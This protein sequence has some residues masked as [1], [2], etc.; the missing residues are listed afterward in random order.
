[1]RGRRRRRYEYECECKAGFYRNNEWN[2][3]TGSYTL[4]CVACPLGASSR[5][6][7]YCIDDCICGAG[8]YTATPGYQP[9][10]SVWIEKGCEACPPKSTSP[11]DSQSI[12]E[13]V[14]QAGFR[15]GTEGEAK[16]HS[17]AEWVV[18][19]WP[20]FD[21]NWITDV[22]DILFQFSPRPY[23]GQIV[24]NSNFASQEMPR[25]YGGTWEYEKRIPYFSGYSLA[26]W[27][28][29]VDEVGLDPR[30]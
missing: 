23:E 11:P 18:K 15:L 9:G 8:Y 16:D 6:G 27:T 14:C 21:V 29:T 7:S 12:S 30:L 20:E 17:V 13:R 24:M 5:Q 4:R 26:T 28:I 3:Y 22:E 1:M 19:R 10:S 25:E 2:Y